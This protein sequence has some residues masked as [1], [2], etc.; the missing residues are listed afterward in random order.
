MRECQGH[1]ADLPLRPPRGLP[2]VL[3]EDHTDGRE[4]AAAAPALRHLSGQD[5]A[6]EAEHAHQQELAGMS[7]P[8]NFSVAASLLSI[9]TPT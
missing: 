6:P 5:P 1:D 2:Q 7:L 9:V 8:F 4:P 3:R